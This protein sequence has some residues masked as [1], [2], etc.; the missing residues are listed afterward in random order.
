MSKKKQVEP[1]PDEFASYGE[2]AEFWETHG[3]ADYLD[4]FETV[5]VE[6]NLK[7]RE[8]EVEEQR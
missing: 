5:A 6:T 1:L 2:A 8:E 7:Q 4:A 3:T